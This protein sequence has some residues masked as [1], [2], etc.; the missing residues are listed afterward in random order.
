MLNLLCPYISIVYETLMSV[1][2]T[3]LIDNILYE[4]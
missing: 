3:A 1:Q 4:F 2:L